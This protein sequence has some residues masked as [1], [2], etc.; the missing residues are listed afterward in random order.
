M[1]KRLGKGLDALIPETANKDKQKVEKIKLTDIVPNPFQPRKRFGEKKMEELVSSVK[2]KGVIQPILVRPAANGY[3]IIAGE[4]RWRAA[5]ELQINEIPAIV[6]TDIDDV[7]SLEISIIENIQREELNP[8]EE[9]RAFRELNDKF[10]HTLE[11][12]GTMMG[13]DKTTISNSLR[14]L[15]LSEDIQFYIEDGDLS[16]GHAKVLLSVLGDQKRKRIA[17]TIIEK[18]LS[19]RETENLAQKTSG[20]TPRTRKIKD[21]EISSIEEELRHKLGTKINILHGKKRGKIEI[22][23]YSNDDLQRLLHL[24]LQ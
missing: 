22:Q 12:I 2:E 21:P 24:I 23:Y 1:G 9:A 8:I 14:L 16:A 13:K 20:K 7:N 19:V 6:R 4:R 17:K 11:I 18:G 10:K 5:Q 15:G 3:E